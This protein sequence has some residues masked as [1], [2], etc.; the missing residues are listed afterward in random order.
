MLDFRI[1]W[2]CRSDVRVQELT[3]M[4]GNPHGHVRSPAEAELRNNRR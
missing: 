1:G 3:G 2:D 4:R